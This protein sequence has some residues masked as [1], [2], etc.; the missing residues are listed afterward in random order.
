LLDAMA[1]SNYLAL[2][3]LEKVV[4]AKMTA[5]PFGA[6]LIAISAAVSDELV[7]ALLDARRAGHPVALLAIGESAPTNVPDGVQTYWLG[8]RA[9][10]EKLMLLDL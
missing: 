1:W 2:V 7:A 6:T 10:Y 5:L 8:G 9:A 4:R 3:S